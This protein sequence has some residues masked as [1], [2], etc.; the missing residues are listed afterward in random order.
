MIGR[1]VVS[2]LL[3][4][5]LF[6][7]QPPA[8]AAETV[9]SYRSV[10]LPCRGD[11]GAPLIALRAFRQNGAAR[12][13]VVDP[14]TL[15]TRI[16][17]A[18]SVDFAL[19]PAREELATTP[20]MTALARHTAPP[21]RLQNQG[22]RHADLPVD[23]EFLTVDLCPSHRPFEREFFETLASLSRKEKGPVPVAISVSGAW[24][25]RHLSE[26]AWLKGEVASGRLAITWVN[27][28]LTHPY[29]S[30][31]PL[32][33]TFL[34]TPGTDFA[35]EV[36]GTETLLIEAGLTPS[37]FFRFP[38]LVSDERCVRKLKEFGLI[39]IGSDAW[40]A[41]GEKPRP[42]SFILVHGN[43]NEPRGIRLILPILRAPSPPRLLP[44][45][46][47]FASRP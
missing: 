12:Y 25:T 6:W 2:L 21:Y 3:G 24:L 16:V 39:P 19:P 41:K 37:P 15:A 35:R 42:G 23:G 46:R 10:F 7:Q 28:S 1:L 30:R 11:R 36:L 22:A 38:G 33:R 44:L 17:P 27:H 4:I 43:G 13:L 18:A 31:A 20:Y 26:L 45:A 32:D 47:A 5:F 40:L 29:D 34:L 14:R 8:R 9:S